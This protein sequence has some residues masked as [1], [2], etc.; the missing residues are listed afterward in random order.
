M[1]GES[2]PSRPITVDLL[3]SELLAFADRYLEGLSEAADWG[4]DHAP[5]PKARAAFRQTKVIYVT[6]AVTVVTE[7]D[8]LRVLR[9]LLVMVRL[10]LLVWR[11]EGFAT[12]ATPAARARMVEAL[13]RLDGQI[14]LLAARVLPREAI[15]LVH[16]LVAQWRDA[17]PDRRYVAFTR[18]ADLGDSAQRRR[19]EEHVAA[20]GLLAPVVEAKEELHELRRVAERG[21]FLINH[22]PLLL[23]WQAEALVY[24]AVKL[25]EVQTVLTDLERY[26]QSAEGLAAAM[27]TLSERVADE[28]SAAIGQLVAAV[29]LER[30][31]TL[32]QFG[33]L[34]ARER[35]A[36]AGLLSRSGRELLPL[37]EQL[38]RTADGSRETLRL[39]AQIRGEEGGDEF[40]LAQAQALAETTIRLTDQTQ[41]LVHAIGELVTS[42]DVGASMLQLDAMLAR[43]ERRLFGY[44]A[45]LVVL[46]VALVL[47]ALMLSTRLRRPA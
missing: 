15:D 34:L 28:R 46:T 9:D 35:E 37:A 31:A 17:H 39:V 45:G 1:G 36:F 12:W 20:G 3:Q 41:G 22:M 2:S 27:A 26:A 24:N 13:H 5:D 8:P 11:G 30:Q 38:A 23:E 21:I 33:L 42:E 19:Y 47:L 25:P 10:Q 16:A 6:A 29:G 4:A 7:P 43:H 32:E 14:D 44:A 18:F 40:T